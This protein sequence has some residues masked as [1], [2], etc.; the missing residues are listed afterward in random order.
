MQAC[1]SGSHTFTLVAWSHV[2]LR[3]PILQPAACRHVQLMRCGSK[4]HIIL[5]RAMS[6]PRLED[7]RQEKYKHKKKC[8]EICSL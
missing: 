4:P 1:V 8:S 2:Q 6:E 7:I 5:I 3:S